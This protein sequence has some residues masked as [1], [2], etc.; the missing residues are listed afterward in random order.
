ME[1]HSGQ[2]TG[3]PIPHNLSVG[4]TLCE[5][6]HLIENGCFYDDVC[7]LD[8]TGKCF[9]EQNRKEKERVIMK[10][11]IKYGNMPD[12]YKLDRNYYIE[13]GGID[14]APSFKEYLDR[15]KEEY[16]PQILAIK[17]AVEEADLLNTAA[18]EIAN[19]IWFE[20]SDDTAQAFTWRAWGDLIQSIRN[21]REGYMAF[22]MK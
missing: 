12:K 9:E 1:R 5:E 17:K 7:R 20:L 19:K 21:K 16:Q 8:E 13:R 18:S 10:A 11:V 2:Y 15:Y 22:Y 3:F 4:M 6:L 14:P